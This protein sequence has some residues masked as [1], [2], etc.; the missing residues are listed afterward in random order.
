MLAEHLQDQAVRYVSGAMTA[1]D[2]ESFEVIM[3]W[4]PELRALVAGMQDAVAGLVIAAA[5]S[6]EHPPRGLKARLLGAVDA[7]PARTDPVSLVVTDVEGCIEWV[8]P[9]FTTMCGFTL[10]E[11]KGRKPGHLLQGPETDPAAVARIRESV[12]ARRACRE[13]LVNYHKDGS[14]Y[15]VEVS[16]APMP[17][18]E[19]RPLWLVARE[20]KLPDLVRVAG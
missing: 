17:D 18:E 11:L 3:E 7:L 2:R 14:S 19:G 16:I 20:R 10:E 15:R 12:H 6:L 4:R 8:N 1:A 9:A 13:T 5:P